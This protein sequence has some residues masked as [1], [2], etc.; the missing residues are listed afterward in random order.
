[1]DIVPGLT[2]GAARKSGPAGSPDRHDGEASALSYDDRRNDN[3]NA[4]SN[5]QG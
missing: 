4:S 2:A 3:L 5:Q 1:L